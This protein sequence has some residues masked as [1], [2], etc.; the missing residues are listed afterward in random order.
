MGASVAALGPNS[1]QLAGETSTA[2]CSMQEFVCERP[3]S[4]GMIR[5]PCG[6]EFHQTCLR[7]MLEASCLGFEVDGGGGRRGARNVLGQT[8]PA[9]HP[10]TGA[11]VCEEP[12]PWRDLLEH[13][14]L[15][16][17]ATPAAL[18]EWQRDMCAKFVRCSKVTQFCPGKCGRVCLAATLPTNSSNTVFCEQCEVSFCFKCSAGW[19]SDH[20]PATCAQMQTWV[21]AVGSQLD[22]SCANTGEF[23]D[24]LYILQNTVRCPGQSSPPSINQRGKYERERKKETT[25]S[26]LTC[27]SFSSIG[28]SSDQYLFSSYCW[29]GC[30]RRVQK[31]TGCAHLT[32]GASRYGLPSSESLCSL[33]SS[34]S[35][36]YFSSK[37]KK[38]KNRRQRLA[39]QG[40][41][42]EF[43]REV[44]GAS[45][46]HQLR[47]V[48][49]QPA[50]QGA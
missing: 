14:K 36:S 24:M 40:L 4:G 21:T 49:L 16:G 38:K 50:E 39:G 43:L 19:P 25:S 7:S 12:I 23:L 2:C 20:R 28:R 1:C 6:H 31:S 18:L 22:S 26:K 29:A 33:P 44:R 11:R 5:L 32:C 9:L 46:G 17:N 45:V 37:K 35:S 34:F 10:T 13:G 41:R 42:H 15:F 8:C 3:E 27:F 48:L 30:G 47:L